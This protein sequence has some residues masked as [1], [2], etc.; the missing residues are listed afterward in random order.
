MAQEKQ[1]RM[2][3]FDDSNSSSQLKPMMEK[4]TFDVRDPNPYAS[5]PEKT[6]TV[7]VSINDM[8]FD[9]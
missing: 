9:D 4:Q 6:K 2:Q 7:C 3:N 1:K 8:V 5:D